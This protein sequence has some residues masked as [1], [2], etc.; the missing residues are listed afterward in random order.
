MINMDDGAYEADFDGN[1]ARVYNNSCKPGMEYN[2]LEF[3]KIHMNL[4][5]MMIDLQASPGRAL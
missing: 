3:M 2:P 5:L 1:F 4:A